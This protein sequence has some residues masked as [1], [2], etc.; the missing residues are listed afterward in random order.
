[1]NEKNELEVLVVLFGLEKYQIS[2]KNCI[3]TL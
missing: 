2:R 3:V 1:M